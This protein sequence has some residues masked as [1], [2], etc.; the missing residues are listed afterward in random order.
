M[1]QDT[2]HRD[3]FTN[4]QRDGATVTLEVRSGLLERASSVIQTAIVVVLSVIAVARPDADPAY[5][6][7]CVFLVLFSLF[8]VL[9]CIAKFRP[10]R[11]RFDFD[12]QLC[13]FETLPGFGAVI[14]FSEIV[15]VDLLSYDT[16]CW[17]GLCLRRRRRRLRIQFVSCVEGITV[18]N[19]RHPPEVAVNDSQ[20]LADA[21]SSLLEKPTRTFTNAS[22]FWLSWR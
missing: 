18:F 12:Q 4:L 3:G 6:L 21:V 5:L 19:K 17:L 14:P 13:R 16:G 8:C 9:R 10:R 22:S 1:T 20:P 11:F 15:A 2:I 7:F